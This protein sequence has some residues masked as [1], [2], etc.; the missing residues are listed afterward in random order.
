MTP[1][2]LAIVGGVL[3]G[4]LAAVVV[5]LLRR[6][7]FLARLQSFQ[8]AQLEQWSPIIDSIVPGQGQLPTPQTAAEIQ[9]TLRRNWMGI[10][11]RMTGPPL[12][13]TIPTSA[14]VPALEHGDRDEFETEDAAAPLRP[15]LEER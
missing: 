14:K 11:P 13:E 3:I 8:A 10:A 1:L 5:W 4:A 6:V 7:R 9:E 15:T 2:S 12:D